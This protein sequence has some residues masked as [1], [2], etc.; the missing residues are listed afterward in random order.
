MTKEWRKEMANTRTINQCVGVAHCS[1]NNVLFL[2]IYIQI[3]TRMRGVAIDFT[4]GRRPSVS[5]NNDKLLDIS[6][7]FT[8][9]IISQLVKLILKLFNPRSNH[10]YSFLDSFQ[11]RLK[12]WLNFI[13][14]QINTE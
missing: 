4:T 6:L 11:L 13:L 10:F 8:L 2:I 9:R 5:T 7:L 14:K 1:C 12:K 3:R